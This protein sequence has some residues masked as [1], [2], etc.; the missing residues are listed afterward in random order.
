MRIIPV[1]AAFLALS[2]GVARAADAVPATTFFPVFPHEALSDM[3]PQW[4]P[5]A[6]NHPLEEVNPDLRRAI[7]VLP[8]ES[9]D[10]NNAVATMSALAGNL[11]SI[12]MIVSPQFLLPSDLS[13]F[14]QHL[15]DKGR[16]FATWKIGTWTQGDDSLSSAGKRGISSFTVMDLILMFLSDRARF[17][18]LESVVL[19]GSGAGA[20][21]VQRYAAFGLGTEALFKQNINL[22]F[23]VAGASS[24]FYPTGTRPLGGN[25]G[26]GQPDK[27]ACP[28][29]NDYPYGSDKLNPYARRAGGNAAKTDYVLRFITY[30]NAKAPDVLPESNCAA[31]VQGA[32]GFIR[33]ENF[34]NYIMTRYSDV[35]DKTQIFA[36]PKESSNDAVTLFGSACGMATLFGDGLCPP[37]LG[38]ITSQ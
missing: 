3:A 31:M 16:D 36:A 15:P 23:L 27:A 8:D 30:I 20:N 22:R 29:Y 9:R 2:C 34:R 14:A 18:N 17:P 37:S 7:V 1:M 28:A 35:A 10:A 12:V 19:A 25:K 32:T 24:Y 21:F 26:F 13:R 33:S 38:R 4:I 11:N 6:A 5:V